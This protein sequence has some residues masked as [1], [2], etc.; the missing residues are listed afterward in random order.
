[1]TAR[2][3]LV[4]HAP[5][6]AVRR[7]AFPLDEPL[8]ERAK[9][10]A[11]ALAGHL[12][13]SD[14]CLA[15]PELRTRQ[16]AEVLGLSPGVEPALRD[17]DY[18]RWAGLTLDE[19]AAREPEPVQSWLRDPAA[20][21]HGG[22]SILRLM[23]RVTDWL[24]NT[25]GLDRRLTVITHPAVIRAAVVCAIEA[26]PGSFWRIDVAPL[27]VTRLSGTGGRWNLS[28]LGARA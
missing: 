25:R 19:I 21:P 7:S 13:A 28:A 14:E 20:A 22:D 11:S 16:T 6:R 15:A 12:P 5:T 4:A 8:D 23:E 1:M 2:L 18:G 26:T 3:T 24:A 9:M 27:S 17:C 10:L